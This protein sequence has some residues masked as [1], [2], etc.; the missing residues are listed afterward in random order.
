MRIDINFSE[1]D[2][3]YILPLG[4]EYGMIDY[5]IEEGWMEFPDDQS[6]REIL[7]EFLDEIS[8]K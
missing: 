1:L 7:P 5:D 4:S 3:D 2:K 8:S 6:S